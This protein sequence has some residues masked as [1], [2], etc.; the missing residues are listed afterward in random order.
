M[1]LKS[2]PA[3]MAAPNQLHIVHSF[4]AFAM[5][6]GFDV[7]TAA[8]GTGAVVVVAVADVVAGGFASVGGAYPANSSG[9]WG[10]NFVPAGAMLVST[11]NGGRRGCR[12]TR[13]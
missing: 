9:L 3:R 10:S 6:A 8:R 1:T 12:Q 5:T 7:G 13:S 4:S 2:R 11:L